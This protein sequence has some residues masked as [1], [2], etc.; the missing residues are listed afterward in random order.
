MS[1]KVTFGELID[2]ISQETGRSK[3]SAHDFVKGLVTVIHEGLEEDRNV[4][5]AGLGKFDLRRM[6]EREGTNPQT[7]EKMT[8]PAHDRVVFKPYKQLREQV[9][10][11]YADREPTVLGDRPKEE[12]ADESEFIPS[13]PPTKRSPA[14]EAPSGED[15]ES[16]ARSGETSPDSTIVEYTPEDSGD[17]SDVVE[18][19]DRFDFRKNRRH[20]SSGVNW[21]LIVAAAFVIVILA[22]ASYLVTYQGFDEADPVTESEAV[23]H[24]DPPAE[25]ETG[26]QA[27][28]TEQA[29]ADASGEAGTVSRRVESGQTLWSLAREEYGDPYLWPW[30]YRNNSGEIE[31]PDNIVAGETLTVPRPGGADESLTENDSLQVAL[32]YTQTYRWHRSQGSE[33]ARYHLY[34]ATRYHGEVLDH[35]D[36]SVDEE[37]L[38]FAT[39]NPR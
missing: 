37:D 1:E 13:A 9:N 28:E 17:E 39:A 3:Q 33:E 16:G 36:I 38:A 8:I 34:A 26:E 18:E 21:L 29:P 25:E 31:N 27:D 5:I 35:T 12:D 20:E 7:G 24:V 23:T 2:S 14:G 15:R 11:P 4:N 32:G 6:E 10:A 19:T 30:I 22:A